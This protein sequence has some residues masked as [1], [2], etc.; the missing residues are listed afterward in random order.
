M[1]R[2]SDLKRLIARWRLASLPIRGGGAVANNV[3]ERMTGNPELNT[4]WIHNFRIADH[5]GIL[6]ASD[7][8]EMRHRHRARSPLDF[9][10]EGAQSF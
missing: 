6:S 9:P 4:R 8:N 7:S 10:H 2:L 1:A 5:S 3:S